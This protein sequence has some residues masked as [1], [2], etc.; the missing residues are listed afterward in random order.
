MCEKY[1]CL[2][3]IKE[4]NVCVLSRFCSGETLLAKKRLL[5]SDKE[6]KM[7]HVISTGILKRNILD[8]DDRFK[9]TA[10]M[11]GER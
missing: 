2:S 9:T 7:F 6:L 10:S 3:G 5:K 1:T 4:R 8:D 11:W